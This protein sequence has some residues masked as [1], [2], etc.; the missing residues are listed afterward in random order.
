[1]KLQQEGKILDSRFIP[2]F[3]SG[4]AA[5]NCSDRAK[6]DALVKDMNSKIF[7][8]ARA[9]GCIACKECS[10]MRVVYVRNNVI[11]EK[12]TRK[13][14]MEEVEKYC[15]TTAY[16]CGFTLIND[17]KHPPESLRKKNCA[18]EPTSKSNITA[19]L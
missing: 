10:K 6:R 3:R 11:T 5:K 18:A 4:N 19:I 12:Y 7:T 9:I 15:K 13:V 2:S 14:I 1:M 8:G 17:V 16:L